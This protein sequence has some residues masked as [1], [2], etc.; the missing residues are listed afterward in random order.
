M[1]ANPHWFQPALDLRSLTQKSK[2][3]C[4]SHC[5][6]W[7]C[8]YK[9]D[10]ETSVLNSICPILYEYKVPF[11]IWKLGFVSKIQP[12]M[13]KW[14]LY[15]M[16]IA[17]VSLINYFV[18]KILCCFRAFMG[19]SAFRWPTHR[20]PWLLQSYFSNKCC[21]MKISRHR[22]SLKHDQKF[23]LFHVSSQYMFKEREKYWCQ[24]V[25]EHSFL[26]CDRTV[27][28]MKSEFFKSFIM[29]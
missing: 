14:T 2:I 23:V 21:M 13:L 8:W 18:L 26:F 29:L 22:T 20:I 11:W 24:F 7:E 3:L 4:V 9:L 19:G 6:P 16:K 12:C 25:F 1:Q 10:F 17:F 27:G 5:F 28:R 15:S